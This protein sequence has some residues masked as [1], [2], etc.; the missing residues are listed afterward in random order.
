MQCVSNFWRER[1]GDEERV[2][3]I[4]ANQVVDEAILDHLS[5][6]LNVEKLCYHSANI[7]LAEVKRALVPDFGVTA[8]SY[9]RMDA[10]GRDWN[11]GCD[12]SIRHAG[13]NGCRRGDK[14]GYHC[15]CDRPKILRCL[16][17]PEP[18]WQWGMHRRT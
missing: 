18:E 9:D 6:Y 5:C 11:C 1:P 10:G 4:L 17:L 15:L 3:K 12:K 13:V 2:K 8:M 14:R 16:I 7:P